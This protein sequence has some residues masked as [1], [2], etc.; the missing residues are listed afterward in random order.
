[1]VD[2]IPYFDLV[3]GLSSL[4]PNSQ[5]T[6]FTAILA[7]FMGAGG[8]PPVGIYSPFK[9]T[10]YHQEIFYLTTHWAHVQLYGVRHGGGLLR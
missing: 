6:D 8:V 3:G 1:M 10:W 2:A 9:N 7:T 4:T 5:T